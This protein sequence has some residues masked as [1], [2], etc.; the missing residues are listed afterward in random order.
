MKFYKQFIAFLNLKIKH[1]YE[2]CFSD[3]WKSHI[4]LPYQPLVLLKICCGNS[5]SNRRILKKSH[6]FYFRLC[7]FSFTLIIM[8]LF[9]SEYLSYFWQENVW[10]F[11]QNLIMKKCLVCNKGF[12]KTFKGLPILEKNTYVNYNSMKCIYIRN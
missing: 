11:Q 3:D 7:R 5:I 4:L 6:L 9:Y 2:I 8:F 10:I 12:L 1:L